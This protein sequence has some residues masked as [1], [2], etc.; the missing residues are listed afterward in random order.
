MDR[1][2]QQQTLSIRISESLRE[3]LERSKQVISAGG[4]ESISTSDV[5]K[6]LLESAKDDLLDVRLEVADLGRESTESLVA[7]R[8]K[9]MMGQPRSRAE[10]ILM[11][12]YILVACEELTG[13]PLAPGPAAYG[14][15]LRALLALRSLRTGRGTG[16]DR[17]YLENLV[18]GAVWNERKLTED[19]VPEAINKLIEEIDAAGSGKMA[20]GVG[21]CIFVGLRDEEL[22]G[23]VSLNNALAPFMNTLF[24]LAARGHWIQEERPVRSLR[25]GPLQLSLD[26]PVLKQGDLSLS[27][28]MGR[29]DINFA[30]GIESGDI[31]YTLAG[32]AQ[33][34]EFDAMLKA[35][36]PGTIWTGVDFHATANPATGRKGASYQFRRHQDGVM[37]GFNE[38]NWDKLKT[39]YFT[40]MTRPELEP[41]VRELSL[42]YGEL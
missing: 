17:Y 34:R 24:R 42:I 14:D 8:R 33:I 21:R 3:F 23:N 41:I 40:A 11:A 12:Q 5:A 38:E 18:D 28:S 6:I 32:Y 26:T 29:T 39:L 30:I 13:D 9:W 25:D 35:L 4:A 1:K 37:L 2:P 15:A 19:V 22:G 16:L 20:A 31:I 27:I 7:I 10:W 36:A